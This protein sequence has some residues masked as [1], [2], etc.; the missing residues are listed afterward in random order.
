MQFRR[1]HLAWR[2]VT[3]DKRRFVL[4][5]AGIMFAAVLMFM[6]LGF[7]NAVFDSQVELLRRLNADLVITNSSKHHLGVNEPFGRRRLEQ[8]RAVDG[9]AAA[10]PLYIEGTISLWKNPVTRESRL[11]RAVGVRPEDHALLNLP[12]EQYLSELHEEDT[13]LIDTRSKDFFGPRERGVHT[14]LAGQRVRV[15]GTFEL[16]TDFDFDGT[17]ILSENN[18]LKFFPDQQTDPTGLGRVELGLVRVQPGRSASEVR[19][20]IAET[21]PRDIRVWTKDEIIAQEIYFWQVFTPVGFVFGLGL[22]VGFIVGVVICSQILYTSVVDRMTL[23]GTLKAIGYSNAYL[24]RLVTS[25]ALLLSL[26]SFAPAVA[27][28]AVLYRFLVSIIGFEMF[29]NAQRILL[30]MLLTVGMSMAA[31]LVAV[32]KAVTADPAEVFK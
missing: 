12:L 6:Q 20:A 10:Y 22:I 21:L 11:I 2:S 28:A 4:S 31:A 7:L 14:E 13:V 29:L 30:V 24:V 1:V 9:V 25:E 16:G 3:H 18:F 17:V 32:R 26:L 23:F 27:I 19:K 8:V 5:M 15:V